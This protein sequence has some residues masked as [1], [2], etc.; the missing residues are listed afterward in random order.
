MSA[1]EGVKMVSLDR[2]AQLFV[3]CSDS[4]DRME[5][6]DLDV[7]ITWFPSKS[8][9][10]ARRVVRPWSHFIERLGQVPPEPVKDSSPMV[11]FATFGTTRTA[12]GSLRH[13][14]NVLEVTGAEGDYD[15]REVPPEEALRRLE[16]HHV[17]AVIVTTWCHTPA[18]PRWR[19][20]APLSRPVKPKQRR[21]C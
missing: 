20:F 5:G 17:K 8:G 7:T 9:K 2:D 13:G 10:V 21:G 14:K 15:G 16:R 11:K 3:S 4:V 18:A 12:K 6:M 19:V 1:T